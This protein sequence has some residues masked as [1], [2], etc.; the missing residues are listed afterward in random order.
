MSRRAP[1]R[2]SGSPLNLDGEKLVLDSG[3]ALN[4]NMDEVFLVNRSAAP[5]PSAQQRSFASRDEAE[6]FLASRERE[7]I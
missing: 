2:L 5:K 6:D 4:V 7:R 3:N 1:S